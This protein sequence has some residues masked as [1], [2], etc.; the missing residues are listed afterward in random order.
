[1]VIISKIEKKTVCHRAWLEHWNPLID[2]FAPYEY[3]YYKSWRKKMWIEF[4]WQ[5]LDFSR[6]KDIKSLEIRFIKDRN[7]IMKFFLKGK[8]FLKIKIWRESQEYEVSQI[9]FE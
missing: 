9:I 1:M 4:A 7:L 5:N 6:Q 8:R 2:L 3:T